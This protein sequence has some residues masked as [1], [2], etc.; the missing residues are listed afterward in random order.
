MEPAATRKSQSVNAI[1]KVDN[2][3]DLF[4]AFA[5]V[6]WTEKKTEKTKTWLKNAITI[7]KDNGDAWAYYLRY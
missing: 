2:D 6:F 5:K 3:S 4:V 1:Q 7:N